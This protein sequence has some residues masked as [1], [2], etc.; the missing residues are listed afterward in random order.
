MIVKM[1]LHEVSFGCTILLTNSSTINIHKYKR[2]ILPESKNI[3]FIHI[4]RTQPYYMSMK[5]LK[6]YSKHL[7]VCA[8]FQVQINLC[9]V[10][11]NLLPRHYVW[12]T[13]FV[14]SSHYD[15]TT[16]LSHLCQ[17]SKFVLHL[18]LTNLSKYP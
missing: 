10:S 17:S 7:I 3:N 1:C 14:I 2:D 4:T 15:L 16:N 12:R 11:V 18:W 13:L 8:I 9:H 5:I 6:I